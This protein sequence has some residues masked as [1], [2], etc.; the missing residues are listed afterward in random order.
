MLAL[1]IDAYIDG[2]VQERRKSS[3]NALELRLSCTNPSKCFTQPQ[4]VN[5]WN[6]PTEHH[7][8]I[9]GLVQDCSISSVL[10]IETLHF[11]IK[12]SIYNALCKANSSKSKLKSAP[13]QPAFC[14]SPHSW[15]YC[16]VIERRLGWSEADQVC[17]L[18]NTCLTHDRTC[19]WNGDQHFQ[20]S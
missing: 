11:F 7:P 10:A 19:V 9:V 3:A 20:K 17:S 2:L 15:A 18:K 5:H 8:N 1:F 12:P 13:S 14:L 6:S 16:V 4:C